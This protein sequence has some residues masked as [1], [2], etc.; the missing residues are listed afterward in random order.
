MF[1]FCVIDN[2]VVVVTVTRCHGHS[3]HD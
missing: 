1:F 3:F 2:T